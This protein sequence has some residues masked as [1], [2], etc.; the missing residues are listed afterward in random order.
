MVS[1]MSKFNPI[2][3]VFSSLLL[4]FLQKGTGQIV[5][6]LGPGASNVGSILTG[7]MILSVV[8]SEFFVSYNVHF[9]HKAE[10][11]YREVAKNVND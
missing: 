10:K 9:R 3:M 7:I 2:V 8:A 6:V 4:C 1:W 11:N 5:S